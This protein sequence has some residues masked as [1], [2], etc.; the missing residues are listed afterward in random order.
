MG[1]TV[2]GKVAN[3]TDFSIFLELEDGVEGLIHKSEIEKSPRKRSKTS[4]GQ[5]WN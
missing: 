2:T 4:S 1:D 3:I 5:G